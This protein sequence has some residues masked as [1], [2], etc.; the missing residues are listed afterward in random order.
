MKLLVADDE[1]IVQDS[2][3]LIIEREHLEGIEIETVSSGGAAIEA[4]RSFRPDVI[5]MDINMPGLNGLEAIQSIRRFS[6]EVMIVVITAYDVFQYAQEAIR[7]GVY[8]YLLKPFTP[9][10]IVELINR[11]QETLSS[12][13]DLQKRVIQLREK[14][15]AMQTV[16]NNGILNM[17]ITQTG[18]AAVLEKGQVLEETAGCIMLLSVDSQEKQT[19]AER[20]IHEY[21]LRKN[22]VIFGPFICGQAVIFV[23][24]GVSLRGIY[25]IFET[26]LCREGFRMACGCLQTSIEL[27]WISYH[28]AIE[29]MHTSDGLFRVYREE[30][31]TLEDRIEVYRKLAETCLDTED[32]DRVIT[33]VLQQVTELNDLQKS[34]LQTSHL[35][36]LLSENLYSRSPANLKYSKEINDTFARITSA[37]NIAS[38]RKEFRDLVVVLRC[39]LAEDQIALGNETVREALRYIDANLGENISV[40]SL[41]RHL[42]MSPGTLGR[43]LRETLGKSFVEVLTEKRIQKAITLI[44]SGTYSMKEICFMVGYND[45]NYFSRVFKRVTG[46]NPTSYKG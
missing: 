15:A 16:V 45:P 11:I 4:A 34:I 36:V 8:D 7:Y 40:E 29:A 12:N 2:I 3:R 1:K 25:E 26:A 44:Q 5:F 13:A 24:R 20:K 27:L 18:M 21:E 38:V 37:G 33:D 39:A 43:V 6:P 23:P 9:Q 17:M 46:E 35:V 32:I 28:Q 30:S 19:C 14:V 31:R 41:A 42:K 10:K 22:G